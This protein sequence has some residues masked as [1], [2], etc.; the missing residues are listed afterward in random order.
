M[1]R[2]PLKRAVVGMGMLLLSGAAFAENI[3]LKT[4]EGFDL[5][6][7]WSRYKYEEPGVMNQKGNKVGISGTYTA[8]FEDNAFAALDLRY[9][10]GKNT[11]TGS[12]TMSGVP[13]RM[14]ELR[15][16]SGID[17]VMGGYALSPYIGLGY[18]YL[19]NDLRGVSSTGAVGYRRVSQYLYVPIGITHRLAADVDML[20]RI[21][22]NLEYDYFIGGRQTTYLSDT[23]MGLPD[24]TSPQRSGHGLRGSVAY[25]VGHSTIGVFTD[26]WKI[27][28]SGM[29][30]FQSGNTVF[31]GWEPENSTREYG[32]FAKYHF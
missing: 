14:A 30:V 2:E 13:D 5:G 32:V 9:A 1:L 23:G 31:V 12:G 27:G 28:T 21:A 7:Q 11:Y 4:M 20:S 19:S 6:V 10:S 3:W 18:R 17:Y 29:T 16:I 26:Y 15:G 25:E 24:I 22:T 8:V